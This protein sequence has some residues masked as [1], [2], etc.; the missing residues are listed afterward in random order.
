MNL[1]D[2]DQGQS[3]GAW[4]LLGSREEELFMF[5]SYMGMAAILVMWPGPFE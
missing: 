2:Y 5:L 1:R 3:M 4:V